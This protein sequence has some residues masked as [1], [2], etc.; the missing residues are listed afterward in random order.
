MKAIIN[1]KAGWIAVVLITVL[2]S[3]HLYYF[4]TG[5]FRTSYLLQSQTTGEL[6]GQFN[7]AE[8]GDVNLKEVLAQ[9]YFYLGHGNQIYAFVSNDDKYVLKLF[10]KDFF[11]RTGWVHVLPPIPPFRALYLYSG[12]GNESRKKKLLNGYATGF[13]YDR[14][15]CGLLYFHPYSEIDPG[16]ETILVTGLGNKLPIDLNKYVFAIQVKAVTTKKKLSQVLSQGNVAEAKLRIQQLYDLYF[17]TYSKDLFDHDHNIVDNTG[18]YGNRAIRQDVGKVVRD[19]GLITYSSLKKDLKKI[20]DDR[21]GPWLQH[22]YPQYA[23][24]LM[25]EMKDRVAED[26]QKFPEN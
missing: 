3:G 23:P 21:L 4:I 7:K 14:E 20:T 13:V 26:L 11:R 22:N 18:F 1:K 8:S 12:E 5:D 19:P 17:D 15:N 10:K 2:L 25:Q 16:I 6:V 24:E 9:E